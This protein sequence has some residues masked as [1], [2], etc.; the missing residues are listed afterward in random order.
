MGFRF[1]AANQGCWDLGFPAM[2]FAAV[3]LPELAAGFWCCWFADDRWV[4]VSSNWIWK[5]PGRI[6]CCRSHENRRP[7]LLLR[8]D[9]L[10]NSEEVS[11]M[12]NR[13]DL[14]WPING[15]LLL[16]LIQATHDLPEREQSATRF[17]TR[18]VHGLGWV[19]D[20]RFG[21]VVEEEGGLQTVMA[22]I[23]CRSDLKKM[24]QVCHYSEGVMTTGDDQRCVMKRMEHHNWC[25]G[26]VPKSCAQAT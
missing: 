11:D 26:G 6:L 2:G 1:V 7:M 25:S 19:F 8:T 23:H 10:P 21:D 3:E 22:A 4:A 5:L 17:A 20:V 15:I 14:S 12:L 18:G 16:P 24:E 9:G 13:G